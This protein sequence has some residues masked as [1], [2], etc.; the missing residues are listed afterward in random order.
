MNWRHPCTG[1]GKKKE[2]VKCIIEGRSD[3]ETA[4]SGWGATRNDGDSTRNQL[5][6]L[7]PREYCWTQ[8]SGIFNSVSEKASCDKHRKWY[9]LP[10]FPKKVLPFEG[11]SQT[12]PRNCFFQHTFSYKVNPHYQW[13]LYLQIHLIAK[14]YLWTPPPHVK[15]HGV[16]CSLQGMH[17]VVKS[18]R[19]LQLDKV[20]SLPFCSMCHKQVFFSWST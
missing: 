3:G 19:H 5:P 13:L 2:S 9:F 8:I 12:V 14:I 10:L 15:S 20:T 7:Y 1:R 18:L 11:L 17:R 16:L 6:R 4:Q